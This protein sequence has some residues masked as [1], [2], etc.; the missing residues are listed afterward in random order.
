VRDGCARTGQV[1]IVRGGAA[2]RFENVG[3]RELGE[4]SIHPVPKMAI[5]WLS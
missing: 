4:V 3:D 5:E 1:V 2:H